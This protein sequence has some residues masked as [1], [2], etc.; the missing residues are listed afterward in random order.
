MVCRSYLY[1]PTTT[2]ASI[3]K[4]AHVQSCL[5]FSRF[6]IRFSRTRFGTIVA[7]DLIGCCHFRWNADAASIGG[8]VPASVLNAIAVAFIVDVFI[9]VAY[10]VRTAAATPPGPAYPANAPCSAP[11]VGRATGDWAW[12]TLVRIGPT[13]NL[14]IWLFSSRSVWGVVS[15]WWCF[16]DASVAL[17][18]GTARISTS[19]HEAPVE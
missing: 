16:V 18:A 19:A 2:W 12:S 14:A 7:C 15:S 5:V 9:V 3:A 6:R 1:F 13:R 11:A 8:A 4:S 10:A 17:V